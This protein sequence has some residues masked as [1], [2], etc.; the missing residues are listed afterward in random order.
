MS[1]IDLAVLCQRAYEN[2]HFHTK[3]LIQTGNNMTREIPRKIGQDFIFRS[4]D[5][6][7]SVK[8]RIFRQSLSKNSSLQ[9]AVQPYEAY[10]HR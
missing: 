7:F 5:I 6:N 4:C 10:I 8:S 1:V 9:Q 2:Y 3:I